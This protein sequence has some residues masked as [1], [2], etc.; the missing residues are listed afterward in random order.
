MTNVRGQIAMLPLK[1]ACYCSEPKPHWHGIEA[2][3]DGQTWLPIH[4]QKA[5]D[6]LR[7][8]RETPC[9]QE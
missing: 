6:L 7:E 3:F 9:L 8:L 4:S 5:L 1:T 2:I